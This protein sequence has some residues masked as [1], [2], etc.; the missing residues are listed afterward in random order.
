MDESKK[1]VI[2][3]ASDCRFDEVSLGEVMLRFDPGERRVRCARSFDVWEGG[4][5]YNVARGLRKCFGLRTA[6][7]TAL[8]E[9]DIAK[10][11]EELIL[12]GGVDA[13]FIKWMPFDG[14]GNNCRVGFN[15]TER[16]YGIRGALGANQSCS[17]MK[18]GKI[19]N[20]TEIVEAITRV[21]ADAEVDTNL[22]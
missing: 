7:A 13:S 2:K 5:E 9:N 18:K 1:L 3:A 6:V 19:I 10:L 4:G 21:V 22:K 17:G 14:I 20:E 11:V 12:A 8:P 16:G 15:F